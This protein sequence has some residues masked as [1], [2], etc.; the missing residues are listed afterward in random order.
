MYAGGIP[1]IEY[2]NVVCE[3]MNHPYLPLGQGRSR[4]G[5]DVFYSALVHGNDIHIA[6]HQIASVLLLDGSFRLMDTV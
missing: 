2:G 4:G 3:P 5:Y 1:V 6:F